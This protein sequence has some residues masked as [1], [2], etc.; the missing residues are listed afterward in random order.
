MLN[1][2]SSRRKEHFGVKSNMYTEARHN[3]YDLHVC[4]H[5]NELWRSYRLAHCAMP[6]VKCHELAVHRR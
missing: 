5:K 6:T 4:K 3:V 2:Y 1:Y